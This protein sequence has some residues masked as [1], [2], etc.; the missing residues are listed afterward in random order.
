MKVSDFFS[1]AFTLFL[2]IDALGTLPIYLSL[3]Q[4]LE[5]KR[6]RIIAFRET[7]FALIMM[8]A[9]I[10]IGE[11]LLHLLSVSKTTVEIAGGV[12]LFLISI[13]LIFSQ[14]QKEARWKKGTTLFIVPVA[15]PLIAGPSFFAMITVFGQSDLPRHMV[16]FALIAAWFLSSLV[17]WFGRPIYNLIRDRGLLA[18]QRLMGLLVALIAIQ[19]ILQGIK[20]LIKSGV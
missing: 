12:I 18:C 11:A 19:M 13:R 8:I 2:V 5:R 6:Q 15:T 1:V 10:Y 16:I 17:Y 14:E 20:D 3:I 7:I 9:F 4:D